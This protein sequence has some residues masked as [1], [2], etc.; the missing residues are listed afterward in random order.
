MP[1]KTQVKFTVGEKTSALVTA[2]LSIGRQSEKLTP[3]GQI[4]CPREF[5]DDLLNVF[6]RTTLPGVVISIDQ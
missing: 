5:W 2:S 3:I 6:T 4:E 1:N